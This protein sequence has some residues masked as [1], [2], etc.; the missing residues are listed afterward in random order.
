[1]MSRYLV[2]AF[3]LMLPIASFARLGVEQLKSPGD[4]KE[5]EAYKVPLIVGEPTDVAD[6]INLVLQNDLLGIIAG[7]YKKS[8][9]EQENGNTGTTSLDYSVL[10]Q[11]P[12]TLSLEIV[13]EYMGAYPSTG[14]RRYVFDLNTGRPVQLGDLF[15]S[16]G[17]ARFSKRVIRE[18][19]A[20]IERAIAHPDSMRV[21]EKS[22]GEV[23]DL[24][25]QR[26][27]YEECSDGLAKDGLAYDSFV[28]AD[29]KLK[30]LRECSFPHVI[31]AL[32]DIGEMEHAETYAA[33]SH[34]LNSYGRCLLIDKKTNCRPASNDLHAGVYRGKLDGRTSITLMMV[35]DYSSS[36]SP[37]YFYDRYGTPIGLVLSRPGLGKVRLEHRD[38]AAPKDAEGKSPLL[39]AFDLTL[40]ADGSLTGQ[41]TQLGKPPMSIVLR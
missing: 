36:Y 13:G 28:L 19:V 35:A 34:D 8:P 9:F 37:F 39:E 15:S 7:H 14:R 6:R 17:M 24:E 1:M 18:R 33:L 26:Q 12:T 38:D 21:N 23:S 11:T 30:V 10:D 22:S 40:V 29:G 4:P 20:M 5:A 27:Q 41:W 3:A 25:L 2:G 31:Q 16:E 32:D